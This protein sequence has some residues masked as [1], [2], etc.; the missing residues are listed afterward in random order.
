MAT[1]EAVMT[2][3]EVA[4]RL[5]ELF[6]ANKWMEAQQELLATMQKA[7]SQRIHRACNL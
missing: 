7:L 4:N 3:K 6:Q 5:H 2:T 1:Q